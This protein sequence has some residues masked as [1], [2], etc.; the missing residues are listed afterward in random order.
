MFFV[1]IMRS[2]IEIETGIVVII[3]FPN[4]VGYRYEDQTTAVQQSVVFVYEEFIIQT[5]VVLQ[6]KMGLNK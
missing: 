3:G 6:N 2:K 5:I 1:T 4:S